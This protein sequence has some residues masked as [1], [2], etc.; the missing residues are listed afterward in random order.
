MPGNR[1]LPPECVDV[2]DIVTAHEYTHHVHAPAN[3]PDDIASLKQ[4]IFEQ[5]ALPLTRQVEIDKLKVQL[6]R[7]R[8]LRFGRSSEQ[9]D[10][11]IAQ[12]E[13]SLEELEASET[14]LA[15]TARAQPPAAASTTPVRRPLPAHLPREEIVH[16]P[17]CV[18]P[19]CGGELR[20]LG[21]DVSEILE[22]VPAQ[23]KV[24]RHVRVKLSCARCQRIVQAPAPARPIERGIAGPALLAHVLMSKYADHLPLY[25]QAQIYAREGVDLDRSTLA[26]WVGA[27]SALL[28]PLLEALAKHVLS[29]YTLH[30]DDTPVPVLAPGT[31]KTKTARLWIYVRDERPCGGSAQP[32]VLFRYSLD[33]K[34]EHP[35]AH[36]QSF[37]GVLQADG[38]AGFDQLYRP[39]RI[40]EAACWAH[41]RRKFFDIH[42]ANASPI[43]AEALERI[44]ALYTLE[45]DIRGRAAEERYRIRQ[46]RAGPLLD[47]L[48][49]WL[50]ATVSK[51]SRKSEL[52][53]AIRYALSRWSAL[54]RYR[55]DGRIEID[56]NAAERALRVVA[57]GRKNYLFAG[58]DSG[59]ERAAAIYSLIGTAKLN[60]LDPQAYLRFVLERIA[61]HP[62][63]RIDEL[64]PWNVAVIEPAIRLAA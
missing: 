51:L 58:A 46:A 60:E 35:L 27:T 52:A 64:L 45:A 56:N 20:R 55:D 17:S 62:I 54:T 12:L 6:A 11:S 49:A 2:N 48:H 18:C 13:L 31:G 21:E 23:F 59:G 32:G 38:Y 22:R 26:D 25:R 34:G 7:L 39:G 14:M 28:A 43:A 36:L 4:L 37:S 57:L 19:E 33:R 3:L 61:E 42:A 44:G 5:R 9:L 15:H 50:L 24:V 16:T 41:V 30:A 10:Q 63:N 1:K 47:Q 29:G 8:R 53:G 40:T